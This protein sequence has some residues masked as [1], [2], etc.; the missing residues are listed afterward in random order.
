VFDIFYGLFTELGF[1]ERFQVSREELLEVYWW[2]EFNIMTRSFG[3]SMPS[4][5]IIPFLDMLNHFDDE[6]VTH[7]ML[8]LQQ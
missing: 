5:C 3:W 1:S 7:L 2:A 6:S 8:D 4:T